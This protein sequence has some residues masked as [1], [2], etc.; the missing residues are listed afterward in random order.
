MDNGEDPAF[1]QSGG[2][3]ANILES[4]GDIG[5]SMAPSDDESIVFEGKIPLV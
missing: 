3:D 1:V 2:T 5:F 4:F